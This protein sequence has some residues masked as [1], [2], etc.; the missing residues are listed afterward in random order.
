MA[1]LGVEHEAGEVATV[2]ELTI[3]G[4]RGSV[5]VSGPRVQ[6][7]GGATTCLEAV[8]AGERRVILDCGTGLAELG[9]RRAGALQEALV[10]QSHFHWD[11]IQG[12]PF[13]GPI[14]DPAARFELW[15]RPREGRT[16]REV[17]E[18]QMHE[19][20]FPIGL[21]IVPATLVWRTLDEEAGSALFGDL[22]VRWAEVDHPSGS[23]A[24]RLDWRGASM[25]FSGDCELRR[26]G[27]EALRQLAD[28]ADVLVADAQYLDEEY[29]AR[30]GY[31]HSTPLD[32]VSLAA[33]AGVGRLVMTHHDPGHDDDRLEL[34]LRQARMLAMMHAPGLLVDNAHDGMRI[35]L[36][37]SAHLVA[38]LVA[39]ATLVGA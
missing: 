15:A 7:H 36:G 13:F 23:T 11:H 18:A 26:G 37:S 34:K 32:V 22:E 1:P 16:F 30:R 5:A 3:W 24:W 29:E 2:M 27:R 14:F 35:E 38:P 28:G 39:A 19:P 12:F 6:R 25:V 4:S 33:E 31:G 21:E 17:L 9:R 20:T 8:L 10:L